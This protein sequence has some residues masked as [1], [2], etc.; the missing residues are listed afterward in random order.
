MYDHHVQYVCVGVSGG[1]QPAERTVGASGDNWSGSPPPPPSIPSPVSPVGVR[2]HDFCIFH[3]KIT[4]SQGRA[5]DT[6]VDPGVERRDHHWEGR[7]NDRQAAGQQRRA[8]TRARRARRPGALSRDHRRGG[9][10]RELLAARPQ[11]A[12]RHRRRQRRRPRG[13]L[14]GLC[15]KRFD[16]CAERST[17]FLE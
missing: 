5:T 11:D 13:Q 1:S 12:R 17:L 16:T 2:G 15:W 6:R 7:R 14:S 4:K 9:R 10:G 3:M 8:R